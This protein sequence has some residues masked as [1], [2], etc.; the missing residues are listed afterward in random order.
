MGW[1]HTQGATKADIVK[2]L[3]D[4]LR[5]DLAR[6]AELLAKRTVGNHLWMVWEVTSDQRTPEGGAIRT[7][8]IELALLSKHRNYGWGYKN[9][10]HTM[11]PVETDCPLAFLDLLRS[12]EWGG[13]GESW[14]KRVRAVQGVQAER[15]AQWEALKIDDVFVAVDGRE[16]R[17]CMV[18]TSGRTRKVSAAPKVGGAVY[19]IR[20]KDLAR[21]V[22]R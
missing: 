17:V 9:M 19:N 16:Y 18:D 1:I 3:T 12:N 13:Y 10:D 14:A 20:A 7:R 11:G 6:R 4:G 2:E 5:W 22:E 21:L 15:R 8:F